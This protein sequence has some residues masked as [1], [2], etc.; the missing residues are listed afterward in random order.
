MS[1]QTYG[2]TGM[3]R[4]NG[5]EPKT[6]KIPFVPG[7]PPRYNI[8]TLATKA[9]LRKQW[10]LFVLALEKFK[11]MPVTEKLSYFQIAGIVSFIGFNHMK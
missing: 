9:H 7:L 10:T 5:V 4:P 8:E 2:I 6:V 3:P 1:E 11:N